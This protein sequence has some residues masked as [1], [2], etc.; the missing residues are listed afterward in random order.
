MGR[1]GCEL[2]GLIVAVAIGGT[3]NVIARYDAELSL[4]DKS[5]VAVPVERKCVKK[6]ALCKCIS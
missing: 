4:V 2:D 6:R 5:N 3:D 1:F